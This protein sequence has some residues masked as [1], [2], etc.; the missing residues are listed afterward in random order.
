MMLAAGLLA[1]A[2]V[3]L[4]ARRWEIRG[5]PERF[6]ALVVVF[7]LAECLLY[8][9]QAQAPTGPFRIPL[10]G[11][12]VRTQDA[13]VA[14]GV[15]ARLTSRPLPPRVSGTGVLWFA[16]FVWLLTAT[17]RGVLAG[18]P[19]N[20]VLFSAMSLAGLFGGRL[21][22]AG[23]DPYRLATMLQGWWLLPLSVILLVLFPLTASDGDNPGYLG[24]DLG[25]IHVDTASVFVALGTCVLLV[26]WSGRQGPNWLAWAPLALLITPFAI[27]QRATLVHLGATVL[28]IGWAMTR[29]QWRSNI[30]LPRAHLL[31]A[32]LVVVAALMVLVIVQLSQPKG[33]MPF[34]DY[35]QDTFFSTG[36]Q[37]SA[38]AR[39]EAYDFAL[40]EWARAPVYGHG[41]GHSY[42]IIPPGEFEVRTLGTFDNVP[43]DLLVRSGAVGLVLFGLAYV[44]TIRNGF[45]VWRGD[46]RRTIAALALA[47]AA[48]LVGLA[49]KSMFES[50][51]EKGKLALL[52]G[53]CAGV[54][55]ATRSSEVRPGKQPEFAPPDDA[56]QSVWT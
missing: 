1:A 50:I 32:S 29:P 52:I 46:R 40:D 9:A 51:L 33:T 28:V 7:L 56:R 17:A 19:T 23:C 55:A 6:V 43:L 14:I 27:E 49:A 48:T 47:A 4:T 20:L 30:R 11:G 22:V 42:E 45:A 12:S 39:T 37:L 25:T 35:Y 5:C 18:H 36:Q 15:F 54:V 34:S 24:T 10:L 44:S 38:A 8:P 3:F 13:L 41:L 2:A 21:L 53:L 31:W 26:K 16:A